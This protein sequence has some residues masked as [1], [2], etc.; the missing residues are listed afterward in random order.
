[1]FTERQKFSIEQYIKK[2]IMDN[3]YPLE[4]SSNNS[5]TTN[6]TDTSSSSTVT[7]TQINTQISTSIKPKPSVFQNFLKECGEEEPITIEST[8]EKSKR[9]MINEELKYFKSAVQAFNDDVEPS[10]WSAINFWKMN[11]D[12]LPLLTHLAKIHLSTCATSVPSESAFSISS[13]IARKERS[14]LSSKNLAFSV[15]LKDKVFINN[16][17]FNLIC[18]VLKLI[19]YLL[20]VLCILFLL[21]N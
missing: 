11:K 9:I 10:A 7:T 2:L 17:I 1:M 5:S 6:S 13:Y 18:N 20:N 3:V 14:R 12:R 8:K 19:S 15:F 16:S 21:K 4:L